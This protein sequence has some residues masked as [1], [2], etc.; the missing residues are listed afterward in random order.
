ME[1][2][3][4]THSQQEFDEIMAEKITLIRENFIS[5]TAKFDGKFLIWKF[6]NY[7]IVSSNIIVCGADLVRFVQVYW[8]KQ[9]LQAK[10]LHFK[11]HIIMWKNVILLKLLKLW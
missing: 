10:Q 1:L 9:A 11:V 8:R 6:L 5:R 3:F 7:V 4:N 2:K